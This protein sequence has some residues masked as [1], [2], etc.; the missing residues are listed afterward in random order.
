MGE[1]KTAIEDGGWNYWIVYISASDLKLAITIGITISNIFV[2]SKII[3]IILAVLKISADNITNGIWFHLN[4]FV[5]IPIGPTEP[6]CG[7]Q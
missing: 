6:V 7:E 5:G 4:K 2:K 3:K 1:G